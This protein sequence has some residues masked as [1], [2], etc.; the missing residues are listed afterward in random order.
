[1]VASV[2]VFPVT[3]GQDPSS[4]L[5]T[6]S[7]LKVRLAPELCHRVLVNPRTW[8]QAPLGITWDLRG[9]APFPGK[10]ARVGGL[11]KTNRPWEWQR[12]SAGARE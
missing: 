8:H 2:T 9:V 10:Q 4:A 7:V 1:M 12:F 11:W 5:A 6:R 3:T